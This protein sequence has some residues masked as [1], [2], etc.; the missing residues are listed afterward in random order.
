MADIT[1]L[2]KLLR[3]MPIF[4]GLQDS[5]LTFILDRSNMFTVESGGYFFV[6]GE[7]AHSLYVLS[8]GQVVIEKDWEGTPIELKRMSVGDC[9]GEMAVIDLQAR[10]ASAR[11]DTEC[12]AIEI[13]LRTLH[14][15]FQYDIEQYA[16]IMMNMGREV[17]RRLRLATARLFEMEQALMKEGQ[18]AADS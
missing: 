12:H 6:E 11:A 4:G 2:F 15:L 7:V 9:F 14:E 3:E 1:E 18:R 16:I 10:S 5:T 13:K 8:Q 17:S